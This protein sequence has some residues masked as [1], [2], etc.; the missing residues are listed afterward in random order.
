MR[1]WDRTT[2]SNGK[3]TIMGATLGYSKKVLE[4]LESVAFSI[5]VD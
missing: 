1:S 2:T 5:A 4:T 3:S